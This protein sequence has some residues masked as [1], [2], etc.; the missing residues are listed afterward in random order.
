MGVA[1][2]PE[3]PEYYGRLKLDGAER[4]PRADMNHSG[5]RDPSEVCLC[6]WCPGCVLEPLVSQHWLYQPLVIFLPLHRW[7]GSALLGAVRARWGFVRGHCH[8]LG[9]C[10]PRGCRPAEEAACLCR[11]WAWDW[12]KRRLNKKVLFLR[13]LQPRVRAGHANW[14][15]LYQ[16]AE[17]RL[18]WV[19]GRATLEWLYPVAA[20]ALENRLRASPAT[21]I[22]ASGGRTRHRPHWPG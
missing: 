17:D 7:S 15:R 1:V 16:P 20:L 18:H 12:V 8:R 4:L 6:M 3:V 2:S 19:P 9:V 14:K 22:F 10:H 5:R 13:L 11:S 21:G